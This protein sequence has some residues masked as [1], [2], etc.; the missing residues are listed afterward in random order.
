MATRT[1]PK[2][3]PAFEERLAELEEIVQKLEAG[4]VPLEES[5]EAFERGV[6]LVRV[7]HGRLDT[8]E[9]KIQ[10]LARGED[11]EISAETLGKAE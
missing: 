2:K 5:L 9:T 8:V 11:G 1:K 7:L 6:K 10:E 3:E 4:D